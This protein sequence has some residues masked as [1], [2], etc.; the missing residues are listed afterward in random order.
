MDSM[1][2]TMESI[3][4]RGFSQPDEIRFF[5]KGRVEL[6]SVGGVMVG[7]A[8][9]EPGW[10]WST[11]VRPIVNTESCEAPHFQYH[12]SG[13]LRVVTD[14]GEMRDLR[15]G[16]VSALGAGHDAWVIGDVP[17]VVIDFQGMMDYAKEKK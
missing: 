2:M 16:D 9:F 14:D 11:H 7:K 12:V 6:V 5:E 1:D 3:D 13:T 10:R 17:V 8:T 15:A 4:V